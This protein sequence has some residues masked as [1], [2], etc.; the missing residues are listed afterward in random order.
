MCS[1]RQEKEVTGQE[2]YAASAGTVN[3]GMDSDT[4]D[5]VLTG[6]RSLESAELKVIENVE[7][8]KVSVG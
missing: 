5:V 1:W 2:S 8:E 4:N 3:F 7:S 6:V